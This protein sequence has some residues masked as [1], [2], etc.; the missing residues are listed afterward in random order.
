MR[1]RTDQRWALVGGFALSVLLALAFHPALAASAA[2][3]MSAPSVPLTSIESGPA[4]KILPS[5][6]DWCEPALRSA[7]L[8]LALPVFP[9]RDRSEKRSRSTRYYGPLHQ[10]PPPSLS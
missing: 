4:D 7:G 2:S 3:G 6:F 10:R 5:H 8:P 9:T 1:G